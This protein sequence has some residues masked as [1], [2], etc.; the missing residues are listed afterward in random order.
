MKPWKATLEVIGKSMSNLHFGY[1]INS[2]TCSCGRHHGC[3]EITPELR[4]AK[5]ARMRD[6]MPENMPEIMREFL[7]DFE[8]YHGKVRYSIGDVGVSTGHFV[9]TSKGAPVIGPA[10]INNSPPSYRNRYEAAA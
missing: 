7:R 6:T 1:M 5:A 4:A 3:G 9:K 2:F 10:Y 8:K